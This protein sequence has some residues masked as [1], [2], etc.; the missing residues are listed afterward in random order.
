MLKSI[1]F[2]LLS[3]IPLTLVFLSRLVM[4]SPAEQTRGE[5]SDADFKPVVEAPL[6][7]GFPTYTP[8]GQIEVKQYPA[9]RKAEASG[10]LA[11]GTLFEHISSAGISMTAP[12]EMTFETEG[13]P[14]GRER[15]MAFLYGEKS[16]GAP[17]K[18]GKVEVLDV[19]AATVVSIGLRGART[20]AML[21]EAEQRLRKWIEENKSRYEQSGP[22]RVMGYN[23]PFIPRDRQFFELQIPVRERSA[24]AAG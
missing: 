23:S 6:P 11:F 14:I 5:G 8:V 24:E 15:S 4:A 17:G 10:R 18:Q 9:Y 21:V 19:P 7:E 13:A 16:T 2:C 22:V 3:S 20:E 1:G 12:V